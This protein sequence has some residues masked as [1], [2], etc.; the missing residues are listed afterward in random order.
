[1]AYEVVYPVIVVN[2]SGSN[3]SCLTPGTSNDAGYS[4]FLPALEQPF[5]TQS[6][7]C[8]HGTTERQKQWLH[9]PDTTHPQK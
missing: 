3:L 7:L 2:P 8:L 4:T 5:S 6:I 9:Q 1:M